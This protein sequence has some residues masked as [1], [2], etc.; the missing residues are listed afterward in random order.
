MLKKSIFFWYFSRFYIAG[1]AVDLV[2]IYISF[3]GKMYLVLWKYISNLVEISQIECWGSDGRLIFLKILSLGQSSQFG[4]KRSIQAALSC[5]FISSPH[6][7]PYY[8]TFYRQINSFLITWSLDHSHATSVDRSIMYW[9]LQCWQ[10]CRQ[11]LMFYVLVKVVFIHPTK[12]KSAR[13]L[14]GPQL[15]VDT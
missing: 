14:K 15:D 11:L 4:E 13:G 9:A 10:T 8:L 2:G 1:R 12:T 7:S 3:V 5:L 6:P